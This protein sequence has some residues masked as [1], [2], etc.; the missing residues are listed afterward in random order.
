MNKKTGFRARN[1]VRI[2]GLLVE[3]IDC[4]VNCEKLLGLSHEYFEGHNNYLA[5]V[6]QLCFQI[7]Q[8]QRCEQVLNIHSEK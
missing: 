5:E 8:D 2:P 4:C 3:S 7:H 6:D 1:V